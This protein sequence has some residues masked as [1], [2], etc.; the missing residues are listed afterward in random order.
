M[1]TVKS[2]NLAARMGRWSA[3]HWKTATFGWLA[4]VLLVF[5]FGSIAGTVTIDQNE[6]GPGESG[7]MD[8]ILDEGFKQPAAESVLIQSTSVDVKDPAFAAVIQDVVRRIETLDEVSMKDLGMDLLHLAI[9]AAHKADA[10]QKA[11]SP[12]HAT[13]PPK[14]DVP[15]APKP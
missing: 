2:N 10:S 14:P 1:S 3:N 11:D 6:P 4:F 12:Q 13:D 8:K 9:R 15:Q 7:R 5:A